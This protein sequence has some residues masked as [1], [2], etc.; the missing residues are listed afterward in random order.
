MAIIQLK[1]THKNFIVHINI[2][3]HAA[4]LLQTHM[5]V[6]MILPVG[7]G[8]PVHLKQVATLSCCSAACF[9]GF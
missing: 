4:P 2:L 5:E 3:N 9:H 8:F 7:A 6:R 1:G